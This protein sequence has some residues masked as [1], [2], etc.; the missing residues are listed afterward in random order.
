MEP[1]RCIP[2]STIRRVALLSTGIILV[3]SIV[4][5]VSVSHRQAY[6]ESTSARIAYFIQV[7]NNNSA[8]LPGLLRA[9][10]SGSGNA[11]FAVHF[12]A[13]IQSA[14]LVRTTSAAIDAL[15]SAGCTSTDLLLVPREHVTYRGVTVT[16]NILSGAVYLLSQARS[17]DYFVNLSGSDYPVAPPALT[18]QLLGEAASRRLSFIGW[19][20]HK[21]WSR[22]SRRRLGR[23]Y[24][25]TGLASLGRGI[26][27]GHL[28][29]NPVASAIDFEVAKSSS[30]F[31]LH[32]EL[33]EH[34]VLGAWPRRVLAL[35]AYSDIADEHYFATVVH[36]E[37][38]F[39]DRTIGTNWR[40]IFFRAPNGTSSGQHP[41][42][43]DEIDADG[44]HTF[45]KE[46]QS[47]PSFFTRKIHGPSE[48]T[49]RIDRRMLGLE[50]SATAEEHKVA[51]EYAQNLA[52]A[53]RQKLYAHCK[54]HSHVHRAPRFRSAFASMT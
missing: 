53:F 1:K 26:R 12:D 2:R 19:S 25:D 46:L 37:E 31:I 54:K 49:K 21:T 39:A 36:N 6:H 45:W 3:L 48:L 5:C 35:F 4:S 52:V 38:Y 42:Y 8:N 13:D 14:N 51:R 18:R 9:L 43:V 15:L 41:F 27:V 20:D 28:G 7:S 10:C 40:A 34:F 32:R 23:L 17:F 50:P 29:E 30:W 33:L 47:R 11:D 24:I 16:H 22:L 44:E